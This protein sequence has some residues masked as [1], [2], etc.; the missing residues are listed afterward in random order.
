MNIKKPKLTVKPVPRW[1][2]GASGSQYDIQLEGDFP[3]IS[4]VS[5]DV[6]GHRWSPNKSRSVARRALNTGDLMA[7]LV[8]QLRTESMRI[9]Y[10]ATT[11]PEAHKQLVLL[12]HVLNESWDTFKRKHAWQWSAYRYGWVFSPERAKA[13]H[14]SI[15]KKLDLLPQKVLVPYEAYAL[16]LT[17]R[18]QDGRQ[19]LVQHHPISPSQRAALQ[20]DAV[21]RANLFD[22]VTSELD[23]IVQSAAYEKERFDAGGIVAY[24]TRRR[25]I[26]HRVLLVKQI[27][28]LTA[29]FRNKLHWWAEDAL[30][31][32]W[33]PE[34][35]AG[36]P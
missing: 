4:A 33:V 15:H 36:L 24:K 2:A 21:L 30:S 31:H 28:R 1:Y 27:Q 17:E 9:K 22:Y 11:K 32:G 8:A 35:A 6:A 3:T 26:L 23:I 25:A 5:F 20:D 10:H 13:L 18:Q 34:E 12:R 19:R 14:R 29:I 7:Y 16:L